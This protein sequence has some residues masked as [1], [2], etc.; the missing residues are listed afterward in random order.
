MY[1]ENRE[2]PGVQAKGAAAMNQQEAIQAKLKHIPKRYH[3]V[4]LRAMAGKSRSAAIRA[5]CLECVC[6]NSAEVQRCVILTC[7]M[8]PYRRAKRVKAP[9]IHAS[10]DSEPK[11]G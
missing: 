3:P 10:S 9:A 1:Q 6:W 7:P 4:Y 11:T 2:V 5:N 8:Y